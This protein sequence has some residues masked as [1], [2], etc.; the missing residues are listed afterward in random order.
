MTVVSS[1]GELE[2]ALLERA[3]RLAEEYRA[4]GRQNRDQ[5][6]EQ[7]RS[8]MAQREQREAE[9]ADAT[10]E[11]VYRQSV[12]AGELRMQADLDRMRWALVCSVV[13]EAKRSAAQLHESSEER[14]LELLGQFAQ[15]AIG[16]LDDAQSVRVVV[17]A[18]DHQQIARQWSS[19]QE[20]WLPGRAVSLAD[21]AD[22]LGGVVI[23]NEAGTIR[24]DHSFDGRIERMSDEIN[25]SV[26][27][28]LFVSLGQPE[29]AL[30]HG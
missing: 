12:Q 13:D 8:R 30:L 11:R 4:R 18:H 2:Q 26:V 3:Q 24:I 23:E 17:N 6:L 7:G 20:R 10:G 21:P 22:L 9:I 15:S 14:Y 27:E 28:Q 25:R 29:G 5:I 19:W 1:A 16:E